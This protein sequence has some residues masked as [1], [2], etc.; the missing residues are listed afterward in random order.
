M[1]SLSRISQ[2][3]VRLIGLPSSSCA[4][5]ARS[6]VDWRLSG[7]PVRA[8][9][10]QAMDTTVARSR[11]GKGGLAAASRSVLEGKV[12]FGPALP[13]KAYGIGVKAESS[14][15]GHVG[16]RGVFMQKQ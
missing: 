5:L 16:Q 14:S 13:P 8:T 3:V 9:T 10:S 1:A 6:V 4:R 15:G 2:T 11:G 7:F 12:A